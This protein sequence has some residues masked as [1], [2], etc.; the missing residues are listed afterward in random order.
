VSAVGA[1]RRV[2]VVD[3]HIDLAENIA[4]ILQGAGFQT[5]VAHSA[6]AALDRFGSG[7][8]AALITDFRLPGRSGAELIA[9][10]RRRGS[11]VPAVVMS[12]YT[13]DDTIALAR[14]AGAMEVLSKP[15]EIPRLVSL[16]NALAQAQDLILVI[17]DNR[18][19]AENFAEALG[20][21]GYQ[22]VVCTTAADALAHRTGIRLAIVDY[23]LPDSTGVQVAEQLRSRDHRVRF[24]F[25]SAHGEELRAELAD[26]LAGSVAMEKPVDV[27][28]LLS[29]VAGE[30]RKEPADRPG[31]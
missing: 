2:L 16:A 11:N 23:R 13:D 8:I 27:G 22:V 24:L 9:E 29:W 28:R 31:R 18:A 12:A 5:A 17:D 15:V 6:E 4:E 7:D 19:L 10:L 30:L 20:A 3:D 1:E 26:R 25:V 14:G 21:Q